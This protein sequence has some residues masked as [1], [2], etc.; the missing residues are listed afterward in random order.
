MLLRSAKMAHRRLIWINH[1]RMYFKSSLFVESHSKLCST[2]DVR[3][4]SSIL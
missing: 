2:I 1:G 3:P 4:V